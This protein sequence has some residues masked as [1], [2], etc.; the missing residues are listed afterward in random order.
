MGYVGGSNV[1]TRAILWRDR[2]DRAREG[3]VITEAEVGAMQDQELREAGS[4]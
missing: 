1:I 2:R 3:N 4:L